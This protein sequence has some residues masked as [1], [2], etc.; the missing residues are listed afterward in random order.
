MASRS[1]GKINLNK[2][3]E[4]AE[5]TVVVTREFHLRL[6]VALRLVEL[7]M[8]IAGATLTVENE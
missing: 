4:D 1:L 7:A 5:V 6:W 2:P 8:W 3:L